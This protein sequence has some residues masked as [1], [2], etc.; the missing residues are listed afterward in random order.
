MRGTMFSYK[1]S[2]FT[3]FSK[4]YGI[5]NILLQTIFW[6][7]PHFLKLGVTVL[8]TINT[9][10]FHLEHLI[11]LEVQNSITIFHG[12]LWLFKIHANLNFFTHYLACIALPTVS[13]KNS[14]TNNCCSGTSTAIPWVKAKFVYMYLFLVCQPLNVMEDEHTKEPSHNNPEEEANYVKAVNT[15]LQLFV[16]DIH[17]F[18]HYA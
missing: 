14:L 15:L 18:N 1:I 11:W 5:Y 6:T 16:S 3:K 13:F 9:H 4:I 7:A 10:E 12:Y 8:N 17:G 2:I